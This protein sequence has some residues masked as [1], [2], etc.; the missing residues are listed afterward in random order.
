MK[1]LIYYAKVYVLK[2]RS[3]CVYVN[4][5]DIEYQSNLDINKVTYKALTY[6]Q[7]HSSNIAYECNDEKLYYCQN[8]ISYFCVIF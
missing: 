5:N 4:F 6:P 1:L 3:K 7:P 8:L 2:V